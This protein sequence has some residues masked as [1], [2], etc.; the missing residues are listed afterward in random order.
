MKPLNTVG[1]LALVLAITISFQAC[2]KEQSTQT[3][4]E[5]AHD[6]QHEEHGQPHKASEEAHEHATGKEHAEV[7]EGFVQVR[8]HQFKLAPDIGQDNVTHLD[9]YVHNVQ[10]KPVP[11]ANII[12]HLTGPGGQ[13]ETFKLNEGEGHY[14]TKTT[15]EKAGEYQA[16]AQVTING[17]KYNPRFN[18][19]KE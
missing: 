1:M 4:A 5:H 16:V 9:M 2:S 15:L 19:E 18:F 17:E 6:H 8:D 3:A 12:L 11:G 7:A 14:H 13:K 10:N